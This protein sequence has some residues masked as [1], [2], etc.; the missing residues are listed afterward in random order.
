VAFVNIGAQQV[1]I[2]SENL[3]PPGATW[4]VDFVLLAELN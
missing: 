4:P 3:L 1:K 2:A